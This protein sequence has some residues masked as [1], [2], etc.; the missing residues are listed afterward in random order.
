MLPSDVAVQSATR[1]PTFAEIDPAPTLINPSLLEGNLLPMF[2]KSPTQ[3]EA[4]SFTMD[5]ESIETICSVYWLPLTPLGWPDFEGN[6]SLLGW[7]NEEGQGY[8][9]FEMPDINMTD[10]YI[11]GFEDQFAMQG[12]QPSAGNRVI[13]P[14]SRLATPLPNNTTAPLASQPAHPVT[15]ESLPTPSTQDDNTDTSPLE[16]AADSVPVGKEADSNPWPFEWHSTKVDNKLVL[17]EL[18]ANGIR[19]TRKPN[20]AANTHPGQ[21]N[22]QLFGNSDIFDATKRTSIIQLLSLPLTRTPWPEDVSILRAIPGPEI[23]HHL[24]DLY[25]LH[26]HEVSMHSNIP[27]VIW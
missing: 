19:R 5:G 24:V 17:P 4:A 22:P 6:I 21:Q 2:Q 15:K 7:M 13:P 1:I 16:E 20:H 27:L 25:F 11:Q 9:S 14:L 12:T 10:F 26:F 23:L 3:V 18:Q 8:S